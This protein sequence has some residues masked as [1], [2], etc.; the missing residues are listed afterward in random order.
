MDGELTAKI[1]L[2]LVLFSVAFAGVRG[3]RLLRTRKRFMVPAELQRRLEEGQD[4]LVLDLRESEEFF[5]EHLAGAVNL[6]VRELPIRLAELKGRLAG[7]RHASVVLACRSGVR[8]SN[9]LMHLE[10]AGFRNVHV[11]KGGMQAWA[12]AGLPVVRESRS[13]T[14]EQSKEEP[15]G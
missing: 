3:Y 4:L 11:L 10:R 13:P 6:P 14:I 5:G 12:A 15:Y 8:S 7:L 2:L 9:G 1:I